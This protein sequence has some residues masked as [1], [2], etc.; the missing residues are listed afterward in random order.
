MNRAI[1]ICTS[2]GRGEQLINLLDSFGSYRRFPFWIVM[3]DAPKE[4]T[5]YLEW[6]ERNFKL[7]TLE[8]NYW[9]LGAIESTLTYYIDEFF[10]LQD[11]IEIL[12]TSFI[13]DAF[14]RFPGKSVAF[15]RHFSHYLGKYRR[16]ILLEINITGGFPRVTSKEE[17]I[18][19]EFK[20]AQRYA[21]LEWRETTVLDDKFADDNPN[22]YWEERFGRNNLVLIS[23][24]LKKYKGTVGQWVGEI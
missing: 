2:A 1:V 21:E 18:Y 17:A 5:E 22:N 3:N 20:F 24:Y 16:E 15:D 6:L 11:T 7:I 4:S 8:D 12:D 9:E 19:Q 13:D 14:E 10:F 23:K